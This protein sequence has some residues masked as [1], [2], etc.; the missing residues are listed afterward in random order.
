MSENDALN[1]ALSGDNSGFDVLYRL[2]QPK[3]LRKCKRRLKDIEEAE[4]LTQEIFMKVYS[5]LKQFKNQSSFSTWLF[6]IVETTIASTFR[7][8]SARPK[9][10]VTEDYDKLLNTRTSVPTQLLSVQLQQAIDLLNE[11]DKRYLELEFEGRK[12]TE[13]G[14]ILGRTKCTVISNLNRIHETLKLQLA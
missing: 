5:Q 3:I 6:T 12:C 11:K 14:K 2:Y 1:L 4:D 13:I 7:A 9:F 10:V 8:K